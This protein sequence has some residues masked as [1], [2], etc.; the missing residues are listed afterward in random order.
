MAGKYEFT[1][2]DFLDPS[3][4]GLSGRDADRHRLIVTLPGAGGRL[5]L[6]GDASG[7]PVLTTAEAEL[8]RLR[9][10]LDALRNP[11]PSP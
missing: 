8:A 5:A 3:S 2:N 4:A 9:A 6:R 7:E 10:E 1:E 11:P